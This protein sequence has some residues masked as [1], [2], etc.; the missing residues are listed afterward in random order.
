MVP[1]GE[2]RVGLDVQ[3]DADVRGVRFVRGSIELLCDEGAGGVIA[4]AA[5]FETCRGE[6]YQDL[7]PTVVVASE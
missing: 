5:T 4:G 1:G 7:P 6:A 3:R 2:L